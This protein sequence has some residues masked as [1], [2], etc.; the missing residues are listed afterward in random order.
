VATQYDILFDKELFSSSKS[1]INNN[2]NKIRGYPNK[3]IYK[4]NYKKKRE[5][6]IRQQMTQLYANPTNTPQDNPENTNI[7]A[8]TSANSS[9]S[10]PRPSISLSPLRWSNLL[11]LSLLALLSDWVCFSTASSPSSFAALW[12]GHTSESLIDVFLFTNVAS[13]FV[14]T[15]LVKRLGLSTSIKGA[16][17]LMALGCALRSSPLLLGG[18]G[19]APY[20]LLLAG[21]VCVGFSQP[22][23]QC[24]PPMLSAT[25]FGSKERA[26]STAVALNFNQIGIAVAFVVGGVMCGEGGDGVEGY[27][28]VITAAATAVAVATIGFFK[29]T[30]SNPPSSSELARLLSPSPDPPFFE[31]VRTFLSNPAFYP[32]LLAFVTSITLTNIVGAYIEE[33][34]VR[35]GVTGQSGVDLAGAA[36]EAAILVGGVVI[37][38]YV[39]RSKEFKRSTMVCLAVAFFTL[40]PLGLKEH[41][42]GNEPALLLLSLVSL[43]FVAGPVQPVSAELAVE[44]SYPCDETAVESTQQIFGNLASALVIPLAGWAGRTVDLTFG[45]GRLWDGDVRGDVLL[46]AAIVAVCAAVYSNF[47]GD[48]KRSKVDCGAEESEFCDAV[49]EEPGAVRGGDGPVDAMVLGGQD[50]ED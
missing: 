19:V 23:F 43:G 31:S 21:T 47:D 26:L 34:M 38:G 42:L 14:V 6:L 17:V 10:P 39:D 32:P 4:Y 3:Y 35:G 16:S 25:W 27:F 9:S 37:G 44:V 1:F 49:L 15:D 8:S 33:V 18:G 22:F 7:D 46:L 12:P 30:P 29:N 45:E 20:P 48:L 36:F 41:A 11:L 24:T 40:F 28:E 5:G 13:C 50:R 2:N